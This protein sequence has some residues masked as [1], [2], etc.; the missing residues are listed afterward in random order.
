[1]KFLVYDTETTGL[2][3]SKYVKMSLVDLW[4]YVVQFSYIIYD[5]E[6]NKLGKN[7]QIIKIPENVIMSQENIALHGIT[8][9]MS[10]TCG[11]SI[12]NVIEEFLNTIERVDLIIGH[13][14]EF[15]LNMLKIEIMRMIRDTTN[16]EIKKIYQEKLIKI[17]N[18]DKYYCTMKTTVDLC[19]LPSPYKK[20]KD[21]YKYPKLD[22]LHNYLFGVKPQKLHN[23]LNDVIITLRCFYRLKYDQDI[24][25]VNSDMEKTIKYLM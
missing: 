20:N 2:P 1:M 13:N 8:N 3:Q 4:P 18:Y 16:E 17:G 10:S 24:C 14:L 22:E 9:E 11:V 23:S 25:Q 6:T 19:K 15:D 5:S 12:N 7:D 21:Q